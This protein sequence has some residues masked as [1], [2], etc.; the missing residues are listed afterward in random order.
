MEKKLSV[1]LHELLKSNFDHSSENLAK[2]ARKKDYMKNYYR[3]IKVSDELFI[4][5]IDDTGLLNGAKILRVA[6]GNFDTFAYTGITESED[7][8][9]WFM[10]EYKSKGM[11]AYA[12]DWRHDWNVDENPQLQDGTVRTCVH[13]GKEEKLESKMVRKTWW[14]N[15]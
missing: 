3:I 15:V 2:F 4:G 5:W 12:G 6:G 1:R 11:C 8:T 13:C 9:E 14:S 10:S 7:A